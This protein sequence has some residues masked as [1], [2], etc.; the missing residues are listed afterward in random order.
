MNTTISP[1]SCILEQLPGGT[2]WSAPVGWEPVFRKY[3][4]D[5][6]TGRP[7]SP[8]ADALLQY[9]RSE[10]LYQT[11]FPSPDQLFQAF[12]KTPLSSVRVVLLGQ[13]PYH[14]PGQA[15]GMCFSVPEGVPLP[16]SL[17]NIYKERQNDLPDALPLSSG[18]LSSWAEQGVLLLNT[19]LTVRC[20]VAASHRQHGWELFTDAVIRA[21]DA[22]DA[23]VAFILWG[24]DARS[25]KKLLSHPDHLLLESEHPSPLSAW[26]GFF[27]SHPFSSVNTYLIKNHLPP[28]QW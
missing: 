26:R 13:D 2:E 15:N 22:I 6:Q 28:I 11:V 16:P 5:D 25:K 9:L 18:D 3:L 20:G 14:E 4:W 19:V 17:R 8:E 10:Y 27:G 24:R 23:P 21:V 12:R 7:A 1:D